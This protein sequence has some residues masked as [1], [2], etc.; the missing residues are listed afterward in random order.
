MSEENGDWPMDGAND[1][2][3]PDEDQGDGWEYDE[4]AL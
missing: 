2:E 4:E 3:W 1:D